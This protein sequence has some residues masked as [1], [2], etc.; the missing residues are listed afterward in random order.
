MEKKELA[1]DYIARVDLA[2]SELALL[3]E[4][5][6]LNSWLFTLANGLWIKYKN[7]KNDKLFGE[8]DYRTI[9]EVKSKILKEETINGIGK[10][11]KDPTQKET[12]IAHAVLMAIAITAIKKGTENRN[13]G[14]WRRIKKTAAINPATNTSAIYARKRDTQPI[15]VHGTLT[16]TLNQRVRAKRAKAKRKVMAMAEAMD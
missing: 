2:V 6:S 9:L 3:G 16:Q 8:Q 10:V 7:C 1:K 15:T 4:K 12:E 13:A 14:S 5:V 11:E